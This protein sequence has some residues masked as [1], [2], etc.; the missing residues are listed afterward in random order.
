MTW[1]PLDIIAQV[2]TDWVVSDDTLPPLVNL[3]NHQGASWDGVVQ[4]M[5]RALGRPFPIVPLETWIQRLEGLSLD[6]TQQKLDEVVS[7]SR[8]HLFSTFTSP[9]STVAGVASS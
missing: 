6:A 1:V 7:Y 8:L 4:G 9:I 3:V 2:F 5:I